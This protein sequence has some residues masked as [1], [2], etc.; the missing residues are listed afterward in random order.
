MFGK[1]QVPK[2]IEKGVAKV[3]VV[4]Q[5]E[6]LECGA[7]SLTM[8]MHYYKKWI[9]LEQART[10]CGVSMDGASAK[11]IMLAA[12]SYGMKSNA[13][14]VEPENLLEEGPFPCIIH[15]GFNHFVVLCGFKGKNAVINDPARGRVTV[16]WE[17]FDREFTGVCL[18][19]EPTEDFVPSGKPKS[20]WFYAKERLKGSGTA[21]AFVVLTT[22]ISSLIGII[23]PVF[24]RT[25]L[26]RLL[27]GSN[28]EWL[29][30]FILL[31]CVVIV[32]SVVVEWVSAVY[33]LRIQGKM[34]SYGSASYLWKVLRLPMQFFTQRLSADIADRQATNATIA[35]T[36]V[37]TF[38][39]LALQAG[40]MVFY[41]AVMIHYSPLLSLIG[42][43]AIL[44]NLGVSSIVTA[45]RINIT[46]VQQRDAAKLSSATMSGISMIETIK[47]SGA[48]N[49]FFGRWA[50]YQASVNSQSV[51]YTR[52]N[53]FL[54]NLPYAI[55][56]VAN[57]AVLG[58][59]VMLVVQGH[60]SKGMV[61]AFQSFLSSFMAPASSLIS[62]GQ[63]MQE[64]ITQMERVDDVM[65]YQEDPA[66]SPRE[67]KEE[68]QKLSGAI[69]LKNIT[70]GYS[71]LGKPLITEFS[72]T[73]KP[74]Q[75]IAFVGR[76]GCGKSTL[77][78][79]IS[80]L[81][82]PW[83]GSITFDGVPIEDIDRD[84]FIG[85]VSVID[86]DIT[87]FEDTV[88]E[89]IKMWD[90]SIEDFEVTLA[91]RDAGIYDD[92]VTR[93]G[94]FSH[95]LLEGGRDLSGGQ[96]QRLEIARALSQDPTIC[97]MDEATSA[98]DARTEHEV[99]SSINDR[100]ITCI[101]IAHRLSTIRSCDEIIVLDKG[102]I[103][104][105]GTH[106]ELFALGGMYTSLVSNE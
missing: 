27:T 73:V 18:T 78:K 47:S 91:A 15:W 95:K 69:E 105:R 63:S 84:V 94:G 5:M 9:P 32:I 41:L 13:W 100:G 76:T 7:A 11:N 17:E 96:R 57:L 12:R 35:S 62:A 54:G 81:Y 21:V 92:I 1:K 106:D 42:V 71:R 74:G 34:A 103:V 61:M 99:I 46:R 16:S 51:Q 14:R 75:K 3:P 44:L 70:F 58:I 89:N 45:K 83:S 2:P 85:S 30:P 20:V 87:L 86:Q 72:M 39:P 65:S 24:S 4:M 93:D 25:F 104:E 50:G 52:L 56:T 33:S 88:S 23:K 28:P 40:M 101:I 19:F 90:D 97:I 22:T 43:G 48:E 67:K 37:R 59:G 53:L 68:Y 6:A 60:F 36:L 82:R 10:D 66:F 8:I 31:F 98:L 80:G 77:A 102:H 55:T 38:A 29:T 26:D 49:G 79:L 64:M